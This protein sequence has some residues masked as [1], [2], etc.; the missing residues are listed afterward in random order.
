MKSLK[1]LIVVPDGVGIRNFFCTRVID[2]LLESGQVCVWHA[3]PRESIAPF[4]ERWGDRVLWE[5]L[6]PISDGLIERIFRQS[7]IYAQL[8]WQRGLGPDIQLQRRKP[9]SAWKPRLVDLLER[10]IGRLCSRPRGILLLDHLH[11]RVAAGAPHTRA[12]REFLRSYRPDVVF[13]THQRAIHAVPAMIAARGLGIPTAVFIYSWDNLPKG[14]MAVYADTYIVW[15]DHMKAELLGYYPDVRPERVHVVG[16]PQF[17]NYFNESLR[18]PR[19]KFFADL[20]L[21]TR[22]PVVCF[23]GN[24]IT[25]PFDPDFLEDLASSLRTVGAEERPQVLF[26]RSP[27]D[28]SDRFDGVLARYP[29]IV[30]SNPLWQLVRDGDWSQLVPTQED[31][32]LLANVVY[33][34]DVVI[35]VGSTMGMDFAIFDK[36]AIYVNYNP[37]GKENLWN[38]HEVY[39]LPHFASVHK[40]Q[41]VFW[42]NSPRELGELVQYALSHRESKKKEREAWLHLIVKHPLGSMAERFSEEL[43]ALALNGH[44]STVPAP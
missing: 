11:Q 20:G 25:S 29:E 8:F 37:A 17:E 7:K 32:A 24:D 34:S 10:L 36:P 16:T 12:F 41:P 44:S 22:R 33:H 40:L 18:V 19:E 4:Q 38:I 2:R 30:I 3:L 43:R 21:D 6:P 9:P 1:Y 39:K 28:T 14:R 42:A 27:V 31:G 26:R 13:C 5:M 15:S 35:N 23:S